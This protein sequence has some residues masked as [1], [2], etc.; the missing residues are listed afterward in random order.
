MV[1]CIMRKNNENYKLSN[2]KF[3]SVENIE[4]KI[5]KIINNNFIVFGENM[6]FNCIIT[7]KDINQ[8]DLDKI[9]NEI[10]SYLKIRKV[11]TINN[12]EWCNFLTPKMSIKRKKL[13][14]YVKKI[15]IFDYNIMKIFSKFLSE[16]NF[17]I[18]LLFVITCLLSIFYE[19]PTIE[20]GFN[21]NNLLNIKQI[22]SQI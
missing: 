22:N 3:V 14:E 10:D 20:Y 18:L 12:N 4:N 21:N 11:Y 19:I 9:N 6:D 16:N 8:T 15:I 2:G 13:I 1:I 5:S 7:D 17:I